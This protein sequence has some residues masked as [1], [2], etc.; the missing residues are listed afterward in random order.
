MPG[1]EAYWPPLSRAMRRRWLP[2]WPPVMSTQWMGTFRGFSL[3][4]RSTVP[5]GNSPS[6]SRNTASGW[7][8]SGLGHGEPRVGPAVG[9]DQVQPGSELVLVLQVGRAWLGPSRH[10]RGLFVVEDDLESLRRLKG[11]DAAQELDLGPDQAV[12]VDHAS[13]LVDDEDEKLAASAEPEERG[14]PPGRDL[15]PVGSLEIVSVLPCATRAGRRHQE[16]ARGRLASAAAFDIT[17][18]GGRES[19]DR[20]EGAAFPTGLSLGRPLGPSLPLASAC[21]RSCRTEPPRSPARLPRPADP[22]PR[23]AGPPRH[24]VQGESHRPD[25]RPGTW[26]TMNRLAPAGGQELSDSAA[27]VSKALKLSYRKPARDA[28]RSGALSDC[29]SLW[30]D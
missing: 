16:L 25:G 5:S 22:E 9:A 23:T 28:S 13:R 24:T 27:G 26:K 21:L 12:V 29:F 1:R 20:V 8:A 15:A 3:A 14:L 10:R 30:I 18:G 7:R 19:L 6:D 11:E 4:T 17:W 2:A